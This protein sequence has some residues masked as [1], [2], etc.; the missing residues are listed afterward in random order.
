MVVLY[1]CICSR[2]YAEWRASWDDKEPSPRLEKEKGVEGFPIQVRGHQH[3][4]E[5]IVTDG[6]MIASSCLQGQLKIW[7]AS[8]GELVAE[9]DRASHFERNEVVN[10]TSV[11][12][13]DVRMGFIRKL[14]NS[15]SPPP[16]HATRNSLKLNFEFGGNSE[17]GENSFRL[18]FLF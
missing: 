6:S 8:T 17:R 3:T 11:S 2:N 13:D 7:D 10:A 18:E 14:E 9:I 4:I 12:T 5:C 16:Q 15:P 1:R